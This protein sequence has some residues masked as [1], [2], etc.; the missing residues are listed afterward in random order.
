MVDSRGHGPASG[1]SPRHVIACPVLAIRDEREAVPT[2]GIHEQRQ[3]DDRRQRPTPMWS[4]YML[5]GGRRGHV[6][7]ADERSGAFVDRHGSRLFAMVL[8]I[9]VL[10]LL[11]AWFTLLF[12][13]HEI[14]RAHV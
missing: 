11:D 8:L 4:R 9:L 5:W 14:G 1:R 7:R 6:R 13:S 10:N 12:L 3:Q 2:S